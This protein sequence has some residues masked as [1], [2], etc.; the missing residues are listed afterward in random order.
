MPARSHISSKRTH[1]LIREHILEHMLACRKACLGSDDVTY[2]YD[3]VTYVY[4]DVALIAVGGACA[5]RV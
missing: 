2:V 4:D 5:F 1:S 3:D